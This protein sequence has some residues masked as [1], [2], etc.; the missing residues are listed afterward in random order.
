MK[1]KREGVFPE[2]EC[3]CAELLNTT[4]NSFLAAF[5]VDFRPVCLEYLHELQMVNFTH[6]T[7]IIMDYT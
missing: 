1:K 6:S 5:S 4:N 7:Q 3:R 2:F